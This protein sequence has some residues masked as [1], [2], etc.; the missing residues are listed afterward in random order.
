MP[1]FRVFSRLLEENS[2]RPKKPVL[3]RCNFF[4]GGGVVLGGFGFGFVCF[5]YFGAFC[6]FCYQETP[7]KAILLQF[8]R[9]FWS[10]FL[11]NPFFEKLFF[12]LV[13]FFFLLFSSFIFF[14]SFIFSL[15]LLL[16]QS[17]FGQFLLFFS[18]Y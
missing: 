11:P 14:Q 13:L 17:P 12:V 15:S 3:T 9:I 2:R 6:L 16:Y 8:Q 7:K 1:I 10:S 5:C 18:Q 4:L